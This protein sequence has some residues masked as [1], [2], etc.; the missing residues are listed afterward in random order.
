M[1]RYNKLTDLE[2]FTYAQFEKMGLSTLGHTTYLLENENYS[3]TLNG[4]LYWL[5]I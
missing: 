5:F 3:T 4:E 2:Q 1:E